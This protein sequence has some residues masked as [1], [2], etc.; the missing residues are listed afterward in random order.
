MPIR[1]L[2]IR[3]GPSL[4]FDRV[5]RGGSWF[6]RQWHCRSA[7][8][9]GHEPNWRNRR[10]GLR[11]T[12]SIDVA[13]HPPQA[14]Q[15]AALLFDGI[16]DYVKIADWK[17]DGSHPLTVEAWVTPEKLPKGVEIISTS[18]QSGFNLAIWKDDRWS[19]SVVAGT[20]AIWALAPFQPEHTNRRLHVAGVY[21][22]QQ[23]R[24]YVEGV[25]MQRVAAPDAYK[26][27]TQPLILGGNPNG[28]KIVFHY[29][30]Q[31]DEVRL[32][33]VGRYAGNFQ[34]AE[35][36][37]ADPDTMA[38]YHFD[39]GA[40]RVL[41]DSSGNNLHG[42]IVGAQWINLADDQASSDYSD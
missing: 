5:L 25:E 42:K 15:R 26:P 34:P 3:G 17:Y 24:L 20:P 30:G 27:S 35:R 1:L 41:K 18:E 38:L 39:E 12:Q 33:R 13:Q 32:S 40:G 8:R 2:T 21:D 16:D 22:R 9:I 23:V 29:A 31:I 7:Y 19:F 4:G 11:L 14:T 36:F 37:A 10:S 28:D 6:D